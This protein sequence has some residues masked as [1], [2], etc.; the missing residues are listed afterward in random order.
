MRKLFDES[1]AEIEA[2]DD[3]EIGELK[4][5]AEASVKL[6]EEL[7][8]LTDKSVGLKNLRESLNRKERRI[9]ELEEQLKA[10]T[11]K[12]PVEDKK[13]DEKSLDSLDIE[14]RAENAAR[15]VLLDSEINR[16]LGEFS[17]EERTKVKKYFDKLSHGEELNLDTM[18]VFLNEAERVAFPERSASRPSFQGRPPRIN[19]NEKTFSDTDE[20]KALANQLGFKIEKK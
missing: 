13:E 19:T 1:G 7:K 2:M 6:E 16:H 3:K 10:S 20:G 9:G 17:D 12:K 14:K 18:R 11:D 5:K 4:A 15:R 8:S